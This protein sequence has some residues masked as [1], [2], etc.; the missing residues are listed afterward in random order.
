MSELTTEVDN[1]KLRYREVFFKVSEEFGHILENIKPEDIS[2]F[3][4][5]TLKSAWELWIML[6][7]SK[8]DFSCLGCASCCKLACSEFS[9]DELAQK[10]Q[11]N[12]NFAKQFLSVFVP[13]GSEEEAKKIYPEYFEL[14][15]EKASG[16]KVYF[17]HCPKVTEDN[18][19]PDYENRPQICRDFPDNP[20][21]FLPKKCGFKTWKKDVEDE[22]LKI[23]AQIEIASFYKEK[24]KQGV[25]L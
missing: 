5:K 18:R 10:A 24:I 1:L 12:D 20:L 17:Y 6:L 19:C 25:M 3:L 21:G 15:K 23:Q 4:D 2:T 16:E 22:A 8:S 7:R 13:Y 9:P 14:L 11:N